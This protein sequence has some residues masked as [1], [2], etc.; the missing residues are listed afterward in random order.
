[1]PSA[2]GYNNYVNYDYDFPAKPFPLPERPF[3]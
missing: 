2:Q 3:T 1:M